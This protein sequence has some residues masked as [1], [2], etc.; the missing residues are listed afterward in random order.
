MGWS[1]QQIVYRFMFVS[2]LTAM[3]G[4]ALAIV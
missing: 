1:E 3:I 4:V 2:I